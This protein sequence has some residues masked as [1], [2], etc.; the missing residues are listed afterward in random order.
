MVAEENKRRTIQR[1]DIAN[2]VA[3]SDLFD[4]LIDIVPRSDMVRNRGGSMSGRSAVPV[5]SMPSS[6]AASGRGMSEGGMLETSKPEASYA[7]LRAAQQ[8]LRVG[9]EPQMPIK[10]NEWGPPMYPFNS[11]IGMHP[12]AGLGMPPPQ[13]PPQQGPAALSIPGHG[14]RGS[15]LNMMPYSMG[16]GQQKPPDSALSLIHI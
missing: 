13:A 7:P 5:A 1:S 16:E 6:L 4:F 12:S 2:A 3:R 10:G 14:A 9:E 11:G 15:F 8:D